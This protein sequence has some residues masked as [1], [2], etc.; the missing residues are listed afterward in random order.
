MFKVLISPV[1]AVV[2]AACA[3]DGLREDSPTATDV[4]GETGYNPFPAGLRLPSA[5]H[6]REDRFYVR[7]RTRHLRRRVTLEVLDREQHH[8]IEDIERSMHIAGYRVSGDPKGSG[9]GT[10]LKFKK[11]KNP[12]IVVEFRPDVGK[13]PANP[14]A[15]HLVVVEWKVADSLYDWTVM[16]DR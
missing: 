6:L 11:K 1:L 4:S 15:R 3:Q 7:K 10:K 16:T 2:L 14:R 9:K 5:Y 8:A 12:T 13:K